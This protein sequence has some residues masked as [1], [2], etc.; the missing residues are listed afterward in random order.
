MKFLFDTNIFLSYLAGQDSVKHLF[1]RKFL[2][3]NEVITSRIVRIELLS[4]EKLTSSEESI[5]Q[6]MLDQ[7]FLVPITV[8]IEDL[9]ISLRRKYKLKIPD[10]II[11][12]T[13]YHTSSILMTADVKDFKKLSEIKVRN[14]A[15]KIIN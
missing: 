10:A 4:F 14:P 13:A 8:E 15:I 12:A 6:E 2:E 3:C 1:Q 7:F 5:I 11:A 9:A